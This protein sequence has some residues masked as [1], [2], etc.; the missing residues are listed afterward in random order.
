[1]AEH[2]LGDG[3]ESRGEAGRKS[4]RTGNNGATFLMSSHGATT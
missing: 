2:T 1:M 4:S 3:A